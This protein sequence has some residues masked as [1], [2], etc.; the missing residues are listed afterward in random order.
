MLTHPVD[1]GWP[2]L[3]AAGRQR[4]YTV[5]VAPD[6]LVAAGQAAGSTMS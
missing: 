6:F 2:F 1:A 5:V 3:V 4:D